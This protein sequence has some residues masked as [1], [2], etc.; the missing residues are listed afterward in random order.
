MKS[1]KIYDFA[2][3]NIFVNK[4]KKHFVSLFTKFASVTIKAIFMRKLFI[5]LTSI[6]FCINNIYAEEKKR[7]IPPNGN[8][9]NLGLS[10]IDNPDGFGGTSYTYFHMNWG[11][12]GQHNGWF[13]DATPES[14][15][16]YNYD[17]EN[18]YISVN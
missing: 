12:Y 18:L 2:F 9:D 6:F 7:E 14:G 16:S 13:I 15:T 10:L 11:W 3:V 17:R 1:L 4:S 5:I 8:Y